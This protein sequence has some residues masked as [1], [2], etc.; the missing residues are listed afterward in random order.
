MKTL[1]LLF[2]VLVL[3]RYKEE[4][5]IIRWQCYPVELFW[6]FNKSCSWGFFD[7]EKLVSMAVEAG[8]V[9]H[10]ARAHHSSLCPL[11]LGFCFAEVQ[12]RWE[13]EWVL[14]S[15]SRLRYPVSPGN[16]DVF[17][18]S[19]TRNIRDTKDLL[20]VTQEVCGGAGLL[21]NQYPDNQIYMGEHTIHRGQ[22]VDWVEE[23]MI[24]HCV[25]VQGAITHYLLTQCPTCTCCCNSVCFN[26]IR[27]I[28]LLLPKSI[29]CRCCLHN[30]QGQILN[31]AISRVVLTLEKM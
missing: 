17:P 5:E 8:G 9:S 19:H 27:K 30:I 13:D 23:G 14:V 7:I 6:W 29:S 16:L 24:S 12:Q 1:F 22:H 20:Q 4:I 11:H 15:P 25:C 18:H 10:L 21:L 26:H 2:Q 28:A 3:Q 31:T